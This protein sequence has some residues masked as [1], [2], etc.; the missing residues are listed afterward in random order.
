MPDFGTLPTSGPRT[1]ATHV[2][3]VNDKLEALSQRAPVLLGSVAGTNSITAASTPTLTA[4]VAGM[5][6]WLVPAATNTG[7]VTLNID[8]IGAASVYKADGSE[9]PAGQ[10]VADQPVKL[11]YYDGAFYAQLGGG[12]GGGGAWNEVYTV[13]TTS[14][15]SVTATGISATASEVLLIFEG[16][17]G[18][19]NANFQ[20]YLGDG[21]G[22]ETGGYTPTFNVF[23]VNATTL[24]YG[25]IR[26]VTQDQLTWHAGGGQLYFSSGTLQPTIFKKTLTASLDRVQLSLASGSFDAGTWSVWEK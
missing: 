23:A 10:L 25:T 18:S 9:V 13:A 8:S 20:I 3:L 15:S 1:M 19:A 6:F 14:G 5:S 26:L 22:V 2:G 7:N 24:V 4:L 16:V 11:L 21:G 12:G 17:S